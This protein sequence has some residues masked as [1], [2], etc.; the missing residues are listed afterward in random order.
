MYDLCVWL[1]VLVWVCFFFLCF[2]LFFD[3]FLVVDVCGCLLDVVFF[4]VNMCDVLW[5]LGDGDVILVVCVFVLVILEFNF[6]GNIRILECF[7]IFINIEKKNIE[8]FIL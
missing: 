8:S 7:N 1:F 5:V 2:V 6:E 4:R 3:G